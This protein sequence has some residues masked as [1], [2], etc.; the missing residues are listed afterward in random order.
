MSQIITGEGGGLQIITLHVASS[1]HRCWFAG[2]I[3]AIAETYGVFFSLT[4][5][6]IQLHSISCA[7]V[8]M[9]SYH[10]VLPFPSPLILPKEGVSRCLPSFPPSASNPMRQLERENL[11]AKVKHAHHL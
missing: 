8:F 9:S 7:V 2:K 4:A 6:F 3:Q 1:Q 11:V 5:V 10:T